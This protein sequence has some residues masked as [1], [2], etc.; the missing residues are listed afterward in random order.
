MAF[1][2]SQKAGRKWQ[3]G[4]DDGKASGPKK[5]KQKV[6]KDTTAVPETDA[7]KEVPTIRPGERF[8]DF[9][10]RVDAALPISGLI[11]N[12]TKNGKD[13]LG[14]KVQRTKKERQMH[15]LYAE[16]RKE[17]AAIQEKRRDDAEDAEEAEMEDESAGVKWKM[18]M[19]DE[20]ASGKK[21]K[22]GRAGRSVYEVADE[23]DDPWAELKKK[24]GEA[25]IGLHDVAKAP[26]TFKNLPKNILNV[27]GAAVDVGTVPKAAGSLRRREELQEVR[28]DVVASYRKMMESK[29]ARLAVESEDK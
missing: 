19:E 11:N 13:P 25:K 15:K 17:E 18:D 5:K 21:K 4:L 3:G 12:T 6:T 29:R 26:P 2:E 7:S 27:R 24:R 16:W 28:S 8:G 20:A 14:I 10:A 22:K 9:A 1:Q 23:E